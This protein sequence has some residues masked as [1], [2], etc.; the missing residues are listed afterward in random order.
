[1]S[2]ASSPQQPDPR[3]PHV[4]RWH[5]QLELQLPDVVRRCWRR[6]R[7]AGPFGAQGRSAS[8]WRPWTGW[9]LVLNSSSR[10][11]ARRARR[12]RSMLVVADDAADPGQRPGHDIANYTLRRVATWC[13]GR[14]SRRLR[15][16]ER[17]DDF[18]LSVGSS[19][20]PP[21]RLPRPPPP[22][23]VPTGLGHPRWPRRLPCCPGHQ[24]G[25]QRRGR[26]EPVGAAQATPSPGATCA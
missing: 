12:P 3:G 13:W 2:A 20:A 15:N 5:R 7:H 19:R 4:D 18:E 23:L 21:P 16:G 8:R 1:M 17:P 6:H 22:L 11:K 14:G 24:S 9:S 26:C 10:C 25:A